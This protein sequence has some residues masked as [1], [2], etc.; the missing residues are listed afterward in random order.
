MCH[1]QRESAK[2]ETVSTDNAARIDW[3]WNWQ[4]IH[5]ANL[6][7]KSN[8]K[9]IVLLTSAHDLIENQVESKGKAFPFQSEALC[10]IS[11]LRF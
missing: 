3:I 7:I 2:N 8:R 11:R 10:V 6:N 4:T 1:I 5:L 9:W